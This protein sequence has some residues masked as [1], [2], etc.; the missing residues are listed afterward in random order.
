[1]LDKMVRTPDEWRSAGLDNA[2]MAE[3]A[4]DL[5]E[6]ET[7]LER[8]LLCS[9]QVGESLHWQEERALIDRAFDFVWTL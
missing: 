6:T 2:I 7:W 8:A 9:E 3:S 1:M 4:Q 5:S